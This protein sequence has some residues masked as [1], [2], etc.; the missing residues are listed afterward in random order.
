MERGNM[1]KHLRILHFLSPVRWDCNLFIADQDSNFK[2]V[3]KTIEFLPECHH[4]ILMPEKHTFVTTAKNITL[5]SY[6]YPH[7]GQLCK[8]YFNNSGLRLD[9]QSYDIDMVFN[10]QL[11]L[12]TAIRNYFHAKKN[13]LNLKVISFCHWLDIGE[14][15]I[16]GDSLL[17]IYF[18]NQLAGMYSSDKVFFHSEEVYTKYFLPELN[19]R[20]LSLTTDNLKDKI[21]FMPL[22]STIHK[23]EEEKFPLPDKKIIVFNH[24]WNTSSNTELLLKINEKLDK[25]KYELWCTDHD[26]PEELRR[27]KLS[28]HRY[29]HLLKNSYC[30]ICLID[31]YSTWNLSLQDSLLV[32]RPVIMKDHPILSPLIGENYPHKFNILEEFFTLLENMEPLEHKLPDFDSLFKDN[33]H[34]VLGEINSFRYP[35]K[36]ERVD[37]YKEW[38]GK[39]VRTKKGLMAKVSPGEAPSNG[40]SS[41]RSILLKDGYKDDFNSKETT[42]YLSEEDL[43]NPSVNK[44]F[45]KEFSLF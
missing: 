7:S 5:L 23:V 8:T 13:D 11:E 25:D 27:P 24:R 21:S 30:S 10:H 34:K 44:F 4:Y 39:G 17:P 33:L 22:S 31:G 35:R 43:V 26:S 37:L 2:V 16:G 29:K 28:I 40:V 1:T 3:L 38:I 42:Y 45:K 32:G 20:G 9:L 19:R 6:D 14:N 36:K 12:A 15:R 18:L 41:I